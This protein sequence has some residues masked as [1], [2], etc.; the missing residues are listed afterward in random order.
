MKVR[1]NKL[2]KIES[3]RLIYAILKLTECNKCPFE[4]ACTDNCVE[5][6]KDFC[7]MIKDEGEINE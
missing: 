7:R 3:A 1:V 5:N 2:N 4:S 6:G